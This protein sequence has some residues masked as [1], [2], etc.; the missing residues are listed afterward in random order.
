MNK[1]DYDDVLCALR[2]Y[3]DTLGHEA[4]RHEFERY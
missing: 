2:N 4:P 3:G 1:S